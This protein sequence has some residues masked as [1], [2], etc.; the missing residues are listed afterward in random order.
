[1]IVL[2]V[3]CLSNFNKLSQPVAKAKNYN[4]QDHTF[5]FWNQGEKPGAVKAFFISAKGEMAEN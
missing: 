5:I 4:M 3:A 2:F 1:L